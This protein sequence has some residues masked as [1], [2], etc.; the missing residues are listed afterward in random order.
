MFVSAWGIVCGPVRAKKHSPS[1]KEHT[2]VTA[3]LILKR[4]KQIASGIQILDK[5]EKEKE[6]ITR[7]SAE[8]V[9][10][11]LQDRARVLEQLPGFWGVALRQSLARDYITEDDDKLLEYLI[12]VRVHHTSL[13]KKI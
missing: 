5:A 6:R 8:A 11:R 13:S 9:Q 1:Y 3:S 2:H 7:E 12:S 10:K 4:R